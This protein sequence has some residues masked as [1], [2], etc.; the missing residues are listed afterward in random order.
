MRYVVVG[1]GVVGAAVADELTLRGATDV[2]VLDRGPL[3]AT[4]GASSHAPGL[5]SRTSPSRMMQRFADYTIGKFDALDMDGEPCL[6]PVGTVEVARTPERLAELHRRRGFAL[7]WGWRGDVVGADEVLRRWPLLEPR[8]LLGGYVTEGEGLAVAVRAVEAQARR[9][10]AA[11]ARFEGGVRVEGVEQQRGRVTGVRTSSGVV[12]ADVVVLC[13]GAWATTLAETVGLDLPTIAMEHQYAITTP[14]PA[15]AANAGRAATLPILRH[16][17]VGIYLRDHG[18]RLGIGSFDHRPLPVH[19][20]RLDGNAKLAFTDDDFERAWASARDLVP[21]LREAQLD[22]AQRFNGVFNFT[23]DGYPLIGEHPELRGCWIAVGAWVTHSAGVARATVELILDGH[24]WVDPSPADL[25]RFD[26]VELERAVVEARCADQYRDVYVPHH[27]AEGHASARDLRFSPLVERQ[28]SLGAVFVDAG[29]SER[30]RWYEANVGLVAGVRVPAR[31]AWS[32]RHWSPIIAAEHL[33][34]RERAGLFD[35]TPLR[36]VEVE[37]PGAEAFLLR[38]L[39]GRVDRPPGTVTYTVMLDEGG[40]IRSDV[41]AARLATDRYLV[42]CNGPR[43][44]AWLRANLP[45]DESATLRDVTLTS[46]CLGL[47]GPLARDVLGPL[48]D[49][50]LTDGAF[51]PLAV[52]EIVVGGVPVVATRI[53]YVGE[54]GWELQAPAEE[55]SRLWD[56]LWEAGRAAGLVAAG[57]GALNSLRLERGR[58]AWGVDMTTED[59]PDECGLGFTVRA[60]GPEHIGRR[61][62][63]ARRG[64]GASRRLRPI[65]LDGDQV[66]MGGEPVL[67]D[68]VAVGWV[69][70]ADF[71]WSIGR[72]IAY[73]WL[74]AR[75]SEGS[76][77]AVLYFGQPLGG[78]VVPEPLV[79][80]GLDAMAAPI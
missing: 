30:P 29:G 53:S 69:T 8:G 47:W 41:T 37:G 80:R 4:G 21:A 63:A 77:V 49:G 64:A 73:A 71:G 17:D 16:H 51:P 32:A 58:R 33:A 50:D 54:P 22:P 61:G 2:T 26:D 70:S 18:D 12:P 44:V 55:G 9:A 42:G 62:L 38:M 36:R 52:R 43:D 24:A 67:E 11:G 19:P 60:A 72:P 10:I 78:T 39:A 3:Y 25:A 74:P 59:G 7:A 75:V 28:R 48:T 15:L 5:V 35:M 14:L 66:A 56:L 68:G 40:G 31:D 46:V 76:R 45:P 23:P 13:P 65:L 6:L 27:P 20:N 1:S 57:R 34:V 79:P